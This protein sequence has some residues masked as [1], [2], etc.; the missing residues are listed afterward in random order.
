MSHELVSD[1]PL[2]EW[3][4]FAVLSSRDGDGLK[5]VIRTRLGDK[6]GYGVFLADTL[7]EREI[8]ASMGRTLAELGSFL[9][10]KPIADFTPLPHEGPELLLKVPDAELW[11]V[12]AL[13][14]AP[15]GRHYVWMVDYDNGTIALRPLP[16]P[17][18]TAADDTMTTEAP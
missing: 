11:S 6:P 8:S 18:Q 4:A 15:T 16:E 14:D 12:G 17:K 3:P 13:V 1:E 10:R 5:G 7:D 2:P 9:R